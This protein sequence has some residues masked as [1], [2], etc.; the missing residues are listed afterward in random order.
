MLLCGHPAWDHTKYTGQRSHEMGFLSEATWFLKT[1]LVFRKNVDLLSCNI[2]TGYMLYVMSNLDL[3]F[4]NKKKFTSCFTKRLPRVYLLFINTT[5]MPLKSGCYTRGHRGGPRSGS[6]HGAPNN[7]RFW[8]S[9]S[10][11]QQR[12]SP[13]KAWGW[14][15]PPWAMPPFSCPSSQWTLPNGPLK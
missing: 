3:L 14:N 15:P 12:Y 5:I 13:W 4:K 9:P 2:S 8:S 6:P 1:S 10:C 11:Q 7:P